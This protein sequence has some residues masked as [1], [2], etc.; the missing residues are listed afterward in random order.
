[1]VGEDVAKTC[2]LVSAG[3]EAISQQS[4]EL[5]L[6]VTV[7]ASQVGTIQSLLPVGETL[8]EYDGSGEN[9]VAFI[10]SRDDVQSVRLNADLETLSACEMAP[11]KVASG[12]DVV[13]FTQDFH[14]VGAS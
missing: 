1:M 9:L 11:G 2:G 14:C 3:H 5:A 12:D 8:V 6:L 10:V 4:P 13:G 7:G